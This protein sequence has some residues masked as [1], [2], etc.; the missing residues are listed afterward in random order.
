[1]FL[2]PLLSQFYDPSTVRPTAGLT[3][4][5]ITGCGAST[6]LHLF[7]ECLVSGLG[8]AVI[9]VVA[10]RPSTDDEFA[11]D[12]D[13]STFGRALAAPDAVGLSVQCG[14]EAG[15]DVRAGLADSLSLGFGG[16]F[17][18]SQ[19][20]DVVGLSNSTSGG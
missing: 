8:S 10:V 3:L 9:V 19:F 16:L 17:A 5:P 20:R 2:L 1:L 18:L 15:L 12:A 14:L 13:L 7:G 4:D 6:G 11:L